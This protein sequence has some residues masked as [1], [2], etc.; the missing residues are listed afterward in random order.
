MDETIQI[1]ERWY[2][3]ASSSRTDD[4]TCVLKHA[5]MFAVFDRF[6]DIHN[7]GTG[8]LGVY[9]RGTRFLSHL[10]LRLN[11]VR[12][13]LLHSSVKQDNSLLTVDLTTPDFDEADGL[14]VL[15]GTV[16][17]FRALLLW[18]TACH[19]HFRI[20]NYN[21]RAIVLNL[22]LEFGADFADIF[23][24]RGFK[25]ARRGS[26]LAAQAWE[27][28]VVLGYRGLDGVTRHTEVVCTPPPTQLAAGRIHYAL[29]LPPKG[30]SELDIAISCA[31]SESTR[32]PIR[33]GTALASAT[34]GM[35]QTQARSATIYTSNEQFNDWVNRSSA[36]LV[37]LMTDKP[38]GPYP[39]A[40]VPWYSTPFG[41]DGILTALQCLWTDPTMARGVLAFLAHAQATEVS[42]EQ[43]AEPGKILHEM[44]DGEL[45]ALG[46][47][48]FGRYYGSVD[49]TPLFI[50]LAGAY[51]ERTGDLAFVRRIWPNIEAAL[52]WIERYGD[53]D[54][55]GFV[56][57]HRKTA[58]GLANQGW[59]D[60]EDAIFHRDGRPAQGAIAL[61]EVQGYVHRAKV[62]AAELALALGEHERAAALQRE[63]L[64]LRDRFERAFWCDDLGTYALA[65]DGEKRPCRV[66]SS[67]AGHVLWSGI[68]SLEHAGLTAQTL[69]T[70]ESF[71]GWGVRTIPE[72]EARYNPMSYHNG[73]VWP[74]DNALIGM[75][76]ARYG[77]KD[78]AIALLTAMFD[79]SLYM[80]LHR[81]PEL[82]CGFVR[83]PSEGPTLYPVACSPQA[84]ASASVFY[85]LQAC[86]GLSF[87]AAPRTIHFHHPQLPPYLARVELRNLRIGD[88]VVSLLLERHRHDVGVNVLSKEGEVKVSITL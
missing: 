8:G 85:L 6:G 36:D 4:R 73:S 67:N 24:V 16:H 38:D 13:V 65:L 71:S 87:Q 27:N 39:Y 15:K 23:E 54:G 52:A 88:A 53:R 35:H 75:G 57:Y 47:I 30:T 42:P 76:L 55:D 3:L 34:A 61:A 44:R 58:R 66:R 11:G 84:W 74:H 86:L 31:S 32:S 7:I 59:K 14:T 20:V 77:H 22:S 28:R 41:R 46:E 33:Y 26:D 79:A 5:D 72:G 43:D 81:L 9:H 1:A 10:D 63:A 69:F 83:R 19:Q 80:D 64:D 29:A 62:R 49:S 2:V 50:V 56:D 37:M 82:F 12:P 21:D 70:P 40:G 60:S 48:P 45:A 78:K 17:A 51:Y 25:R 18:E 68:A